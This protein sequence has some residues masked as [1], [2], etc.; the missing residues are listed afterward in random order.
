M[1][2]NEIEAYVKKH[3]GRLVTQKNNPRI[4]HIWDLREEG[5]SLCGVW[6]GPTEEM[7]GQLC[8]NCWRSIQKWRERHEQA[9]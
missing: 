5:Q 7:A 1:N 8:H 2:Y 3:G 9:E 6:F 4:D